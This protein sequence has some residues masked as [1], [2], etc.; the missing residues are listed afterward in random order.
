MSTNDSKPAPRG[1]RALFARIFGFRQRPQA[2]PPPVVTETQHQVARSVAT[3]VQQH[4][5]RPGR[6]TRRPTRFSSP[7]PPPVQHVTHIDNVSPYLA[8]A[9]LVAS[10]DRPAA[11]LDTD[12]CQFANEHHHEG[13]H[14][15]PQSVE[16]C[17]I[18]DRRDYDS[19]PNYDSDSSAYDSGSSSGGWE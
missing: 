15:A 12:T 18:E 4:T 17:Q 9:L 2:A 3:P 6:P 14:A 5:R 11:T 16:A 7:P 1:L 19:S 8:A 10:E 13:N